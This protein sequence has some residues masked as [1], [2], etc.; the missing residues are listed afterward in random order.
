MSAFGPY[1]DVT[2][3]DFSALGTS[4]VYLVCGDT[5]AGKTMIFDGICFA[6]FGEASGDSRGGG[7]GAEYLDEIASFHDYLSLCTS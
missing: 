6:L 7:A 4:G 1:A 3:I 2:E 5:G